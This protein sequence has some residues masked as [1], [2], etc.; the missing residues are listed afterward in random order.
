MTSFFMYVNSRWSQPITKEQCTLFSWVL[1]FSHLFWWKW[2]ILIGSQLFS[3]TNRSSSHLPRGLWLCV[4]GLELQRRPRSHLVSWVCGV[5]LRRSHPRW[6]LLWGSFWC[7]PHQRG[8]G[9]WNSSGQPGF[10]HDLCLSRQND[11][12]RERPSYRQSYELQEGKHCSIFSLIYFIHIE[13]GDLAS[14]SCSATPPLTPQSHC[15]VFCWYNKMYLWL[16]CFAHKTFW[17]HF[18]TI[19]SAENWKESEWKCHEW[20]REETRQGGGGVQ[21]SKQT[22]F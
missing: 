9:H 15:L 11:V 20:T 6:W 18:G 1:V 8:R 13:R 19:S 7:A 17:S 4:P 2:Y 14:C 22:S 12:K 5:F 16:Q 21:S 10:W 3:L